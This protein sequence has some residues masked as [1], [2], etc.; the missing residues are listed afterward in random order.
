MNNTP[1]S[2]AVHLQI[3]SAKHSIYFGSFLNWTSLHVTNAMWLKH[4]N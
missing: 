1:A 3:F 2:T 4:A